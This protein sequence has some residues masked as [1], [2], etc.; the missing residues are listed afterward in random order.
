MDRAADDTGPGASARRPDAVSEE[1]AAERRYRVA[2]RELCEF[3]AKTGDLDH[4]FTPSPSA[5]EGIAGHK[6]VAA[7]RAS[8]RRSEVRVA[9]EYKQLSVRGRA[10]GFT[11]SEGLLEEV[12][13][14]RGQ[15]DRVPANHRA[16]HWAQAKV[17]G[18]L[19][20]A[21]LGLAELRV[22]LV[23]FEISR[24]EETSLEELCSAAALQQFF[25]SLCESF[26]AWGLQELAQRQRRD[27]ALAA[28]RFP[29]DTYRPG[30][31]NLAE[32]AF[33]AARL[34]RCL[35]AQA[36]TGIGK[37]VATLFPLL[38]ACATEGLDKIFFLTAK[39]S[40]HR[41]AWE[42]VAALRR[43]DPGL[44]LRVIEL[45]SREKSC[46]HP[47]KACHGESC[48][49]ARGFYDRLPGARQAAVD[50]GAE[51]DREAIGNVA[52][53]H[54]VCPYYLTQELVR[55]SD[56]VIADYNYVFDSTA[57]LHLLT[58]AN[59]WKV[60]HLVD[61]A[62]NLVDRARAMYSGELCGSKLR[63]IRRGAP[64][65]LK[66]QLGRL[67]RAWAAVCKGQTAPYVTIDAVPERLVSCLA[68]FTAAVGDLQAATPAE[69][70]AELLRF[71]LDA[72]HFRR[73]AESFAAHSM[74][75]ATL[76]PATGG[77]GA[78]LATLC[79]RNVVPASFLRPRYA[80][81]A[82]TVMFSA[83]LAPQ[84]FYADML[85]LPQDAAW[86]EVQ[87]P[88]HASQLAVRVVHSIST[89]FADRNTSLQP[90]A[91]LMAAQYARQPGNYLAFFSSFDYLE[92]AAEAFASMYPL[93]PQWTQWRGQRELERA[94]FLDRFKVDGRG[95]GFA[96]L[97]GAFGEGIDLPGTRLIGAFIATL[98]LPQVNPVNEAIRRRMQETFGS[99]YD[100]AYLYP[101]LRKVVQAAG[102]VIRTP[103]DRGVVYLIDDRFRR[104]EVREL[105][106]SWWQQGDDATGFH[107]GFRPVG[108]GRVMRSRGTAPKCAEP[109]S[110]LPDAAADRAAFQTRGSPK[111]A[112]TQLL[113]NAD[114]TRRGGRL[115]AKRRRIAEA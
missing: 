18:A 109:G 34:R 73:L 16:L 11:E 104:P 113:C 33:R 58:L 21:Q 115:P 99:G 76:V 86:L 63:S 87:A 54:R 4:R 42:A 94:A 112:C 38:K 2:V 8:S 82:A 17:Y 7:R 81:A 59:G 20:C 61:E 68:E 15:L 46:E 31:R 74:F 57:A 5:Q 110:C 62:H 97:G 92:R 26:L 72:L 80:A 78:R 24:Q 71:Y 36:P 77:R 19:L 83:T 114:S 44:P 84:H 3:A 10:D 88:F 91:H 96:V 106:P 100:Y 52:R 6:I 29:Y 23:Y 55:W 102:R 49:L 108:P 39:G 28:L 41:L 43:A 89:R 69:L 64:S 35:V 30:Q 85:G 56:V 51:L 1:R 103:D 40:G 90:V 60:A 22:S 107:K 9:G 13:T 95:V 66:G 37:T 48:P 105:L 70:D 53:Q 93:V 45:V 27:A 75:D 47:D 111:A 25:E 14:Y 65:A 79:L 32:N 50:A 101:G 67:V 98:G 12:K